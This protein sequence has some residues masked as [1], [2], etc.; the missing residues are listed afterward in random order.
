MK[1]VI[2]AIEFARL[3]GEAI[4][5]HN[6]EQREKQSPF[7]FRYFVLTDDRAA[8][9]ERIDARVD[10][11][12]AAGLEDEVRTLVEMG[13]KPDMTSMQGIGYKQM[14]MYLNG[15]TDLDEAIRL[16]KRDSRHY[17]KRQLT[18]FNREKELIWLDRRQYKDTA[19]ICDAAFKMI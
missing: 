5:K 8:V 7:D 4:S 15:E 11:M 12:I 6:E 13:C 10:K 17:A 18:W 1:R 9:Y 16:I 14:L 2:R 3:S 19:D